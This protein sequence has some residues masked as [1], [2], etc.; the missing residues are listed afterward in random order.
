MS[1]KLNP[2]TP[3]KHVNAQ[4]IKLKATG[5]GTA[6]EKYSDAVRIAKYTNCPHVEFYHNNLKIVVGLF[7]PDIMTDEMWAH[8][9][10]Y[11][12]EQHPVIHL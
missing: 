12:R 3:F 8:V 5:L 2:K 1:G 10:Y 7:S 4:R 6:H 9:D 11:I